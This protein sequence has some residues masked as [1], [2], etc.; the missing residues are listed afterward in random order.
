MFCKKSCIFNENPCAKMKKRKKLKKT[1]S[2]YMK[3]CKIE[4]LLMRN[5]QRKRFFDPR[6]PRGTLFRAGSPIASNTHIYYLVHE[7]PYQ[8]SCWGNRKSKNITIFPAI[9]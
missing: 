8:R 5:L 3:K 1:I 6:N 2:F 4:A 9:V 7:N